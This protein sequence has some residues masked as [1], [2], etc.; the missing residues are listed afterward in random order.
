MTEKCDSCGKQYSNGMN[1]IKII[2]CPHCKKRRMR[3]IKMNYKAQEK[4]I[5]K[6]YEIG[7]TDK[8]LYERVKEDS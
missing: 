4:R 1:R 3:N 8:E 7:F 2:I 5:E 6:K